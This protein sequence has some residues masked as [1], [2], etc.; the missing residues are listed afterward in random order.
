MS[1]T[2]TNEATL[3]SRIKI[4]GEL[5]VQLRDRDIPST[6]ADLGLNQGAVAPKASKV[7]AAEGK[8]N[9]AFMTPATTHH[10]IRE[11]VLDIETLN[12][13]FEAFHDAIEDGT[14]RIEAMIDG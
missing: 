7:Q 6:P 2:T 13:L 3:K 1:D 12:D 11:Q 5:L 8:S 9:T 14:N 4:L 10:A